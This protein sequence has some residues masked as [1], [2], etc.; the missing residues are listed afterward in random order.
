M[1]TGKVPFNGS[2]AEVMYQHLH[3]PPPIGLLKDTPQPVIVL[4]E[5]LLDKD[6]AQRF[7]TPNELLNA[8]PTVARSIE[9]KRTIKHQE[10]RITFVD[11]P[12]SRQEKSP[13]IRVPK[14]SIAVLP[15]DTLSHGK[16]NTYF[17]DGVQDEILSNLAK[18]SQLKVIS[19]TSV[20]TF[21]PGDNRNLRSIA[22]SL[23]VANVVE[24][25][26]RRDGNRVRITIRLVD[27]LKDKA[28]WS[29]SYDRDL[30]D[31]FAI[32]SEI[33]HAVASKLSARLSAEEKKRIEAEPTNSLEAYDLYLRANELVR[34]TRSADIV[35]NVAKSLREAIT[36]LE[37]A[38]RL[39]PAFTLAY[40]ASATAN[41]EIYTFADRTP[42]RRTL[43]DAALNSALRLQPDLPEVHLAYAYNLYGIYRD[44]ERARVQLAMAR[45]G[46]PND[47]T[48][49]ALAAYMDRRQ[50]NFEKAIQEFK[51]AISRDPRNAE[52]IAELG[53]TLFLTR[54]FCASEQAYDRLIELLPNQP[55]LKVQKAAIVRA[56]TGDAN[57][58]RL[59][60]EGLP[61]SMVDDIGAL[62]WRLRFALD[63]RDWKRAKKLI[64]KMKGDED[65]GNF[66]KG[67]L[68]VPVGCYSILLARLQ[69]KQ[70][71]ANTNFAQVRQQLKKKVQ[72]SPGDANLLSQLAVVDALLNSKE[73]AINAAQRAVEM[74]PVSRDA[75][76]G[77]G[78]LTNLA[79]VY[80]WSSSF[81]LATD[82][83]DVTTEA[84]QE[85]LEKLAELKLIVPF[86]KGGSVPAYRIT[87]D[88]SQ[89]AEFAE[90]DERRKRS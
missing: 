40:C 12:S 44:Y 83:D 11:R 18:V 61:P 28:L 67:N 74:L 90:K 34:N 30:T 35:G 64:E 42:E 32:Q 82:M 63:C 59:A 13:A 77:P 65:D 55:M 27:A 39:D 3:T 80:A 60:L 29:E 16:A 88:G 85:V 50:G 23:G 26:V 48:A 8:M 43:A 49:I 37:Q 19:R 15:F 41:A 24:G 68:P 14:R 62:C 45:R 72:K 76:D 2:V 9:A 52:P 21:R 78:L 47:S 79:V 81:M 20:M 73:A 56:K 57:S 58:L 53:N 89:L 5:V 36:L 7:Q 71:G 70:P 87:A 69:R 38:V 54:Q 10:V 17:A 6:P 66:V 33:A 86:K 1:L 51:E 25:T 46:L 22:E 75:K 31:I 84:A 4:L